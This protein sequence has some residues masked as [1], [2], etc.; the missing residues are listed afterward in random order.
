MSV[1]RAP[2]ESD[3]EWR[4]LHGELPEPARP[5]GETCPVH[6]PYVPQSL[7]DADCHSLETMALVDGACRFLE[8]A[9]SASGGR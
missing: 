5:P 2:R 3:A 6:G 8:L 7:L 1:T 9:V 4:D